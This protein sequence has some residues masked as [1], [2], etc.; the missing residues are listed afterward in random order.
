[1][2]FRILSASSIGN[3]GKR[4]VPSPLQTQI[5]RSYQGFVF[6]RALARL[7]ALSEGD[8]P[9][10]RDLANLFYGWGNPSHAANPEYLR[11]CIKLARESPGPIL[12]CGSGLS[13][14]VLGLEAAHGRSSVHTLE[15]IPFWAQKV[16][17]IL[18]ENEIARVNLHVAPLRNYGRY[19]WYDPPLAQMPSEF[20]L[21]ICD[22][23]PRKTLGRRYGLLPQ[24]F[25]R[26]SAQFLI[27]L[28]DVHRSQDQELLA[29]WA[30]EYGLI[31][32]IRGTRNKFALL[33]REEPKATGQVVGN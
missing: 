32:E 8:W 18:D 20:S 10:D 26:L 15:H 31:A 29:R 28:D 33:K 3:A 14:I 1:M 24:M 11:F 12:E 22:G 27:L 7:R 9:T 6:K 13:T 25:S 5:K 19:H 23:P 4:I 2:T 16:Q 21:V 30:D 17:K